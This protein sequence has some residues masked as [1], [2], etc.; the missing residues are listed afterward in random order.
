MQSHLFHFR[1]ATWYTRLP[2]SYLRL[3]DLR[4]LY[5]I[6]RFEKQIGDAAGRL[7]A[8]H[9]REKKTY[10]SN[11]NIDKSKTKDNYS[12]DVI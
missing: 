12:C 7:G 5:T 8:H 3:E 4:M 11:L 10:T 9:E 6:L 1:R 2:V